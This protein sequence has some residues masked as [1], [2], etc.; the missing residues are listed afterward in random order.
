M[1]AITVLTADKDSS[2]N[3]EAIIDRF[4][5]EKIP[6]IVRWKKFSFYLPIILTMTSLVFLFMAFYDLTYNPDKVKIHLIT[7]F[8]FAGIMCVVAIILIGCY[9]TKKQREKIGALVKDDMDIQNLIIK[10]ADEMYVQRKNYLQK[11]LS[12]LKEDSYI[13]TVTEQITK[14]II[15]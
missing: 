1:N 4:K 14:K 11:Q 7:G 9:P 2:K 5:K 10:K 3:E 15:G 12:E 6:S 8:L 13:V